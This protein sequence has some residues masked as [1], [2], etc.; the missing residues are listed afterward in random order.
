MVGH[1]CAPAHTRQVFLLLM[2]IEKNNTE[3]G[4]LIM[5]KF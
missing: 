3:E 2:E 1:T 5:T 4:L